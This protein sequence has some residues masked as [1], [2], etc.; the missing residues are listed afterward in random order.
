MTAVL[1]FGGVYAAGVFGWDSLTMTVFGIVLSVFA[2]F[3]GLIGGWL[4]DTFGSKRALLILDQRHLA[5]PDPGGVDDPGRS[6]SS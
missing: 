5:R 2:V 3:G 6:S 4:D 1:V